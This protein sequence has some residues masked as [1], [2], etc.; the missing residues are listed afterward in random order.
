MAKVCI[1]QEITD[2]IKKQIPS[3][4][5]RQISL[6]DK[7]KR[8]Q[9]ITEIVDEFYKNN[10]L[11]DEGDRIVL[12]K[13]IEDKIVETQKERLT[14]AAQ[15]KRNVEAVGRKESDTFLDKLN[16]ISSIDDFSDELIEEGVAIKLG[17]RLTGNEIKKLI[18]ASDRINKFLDSN[19]NLSQQAF[20]QDGKRTKEFGEAFKN[21]QQTINSVNPSSFG[22]KLV[23]TLNANL[24]FNTKSGLTNI[25]S[26]TGFALTGLSLIHI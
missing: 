7:E 22:K 11:A 10:L 9:S 18:D 15:Y 16:Q 12:Q 3:K 8:T 25:I 5:L 20:D 19:S 4:T 1:P 24:L 26:N 13:G 6:L 2:L 17:A 21:Y 14:K 23:S